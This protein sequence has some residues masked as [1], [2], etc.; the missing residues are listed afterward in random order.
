MATKS[1]PDFEV[2]IEVWR[3]TE[4]RGGATYRTEFVEER[5]VPMEQRFKS[6]DPDLVFSSLS[7][8]RTEELLAKGMNTI[9]RVRS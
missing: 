5:W 9:R 8:T 4:R 2:L 7:T 6:G 1:T 3:I